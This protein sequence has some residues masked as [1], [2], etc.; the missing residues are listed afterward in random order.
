MDLANKNEA[1]IA[2]L[3]GGSS[4]TSDRINQN[5][6]DIVA[7]NSAIVA[8]QNSN[9]GGLDNR[10]TQNEAE[11]LQNEQNINTNASDISTNANSIATILSSSNQNTIDINT[12]KDEI[13]ANLSRIDVNILAITAL[14]TDVADHE[15]RIS[16][17]EAAIGVSQSLLLVH[18]TAAGINGG[19]S[20]AGT[21]TPRNIDTVREN[22]LGGVS[23]T[24]SVTI[25][26][27]EYEVEGLAVVKGSAHQ[28]RL[29]IGGT[30]F[31]YGM[32]LHVDGESSFKGK[33][34]IS[35]LTIIQLETN[36]D[37]EVIDSGFGQANTFGT[38]NVFASLYIK[39]V[40]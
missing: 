20:V 3:G 9:V 38:R 30:E 14:E 18:E 16:M 4:N 11:I 1:D 40:G 26:A 25:D 8:L 10:V 31:I 33:F 21:W 13:D 36:V 17:L 29:N 5:E 37:V 19:T 39:K 27:G 22:T 2:S 12:N 32:S 7:L 15:S 28:S 35:G 34:S 23:G 24:T 6:L